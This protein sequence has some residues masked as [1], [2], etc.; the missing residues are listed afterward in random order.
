MSN[1]DFSGWSNQDINDT[2]LKHVK[3]LEQ[4]AKSI[5]E[6]KK[7]HSKGEI[8]EAYAKTIEANKDEISGLKVKINKLTQKSEKQAKSIDELSGVVI[9]LSDWI[10]N[11]TCFDDEY[12]LTKVRAIATKHKTNKQDK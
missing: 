6:L 3:Q 10:E 9:E 1:I 4:Q 7:K 2:I 8:N 5:A 11:S 12:D